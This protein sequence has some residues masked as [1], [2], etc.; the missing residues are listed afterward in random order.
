M[1]IL[2]DLL[3]LFLADLIAMIPV[4]IGKEGFKESRKIVVEGLLEDERKCLR[5]CINK[6]GEFVQLNLSDY[7]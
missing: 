5:V 1:A 6:I 4:V 3:H 7:L 2:N